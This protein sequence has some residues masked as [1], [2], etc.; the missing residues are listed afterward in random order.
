ME[1]DITSPNNLAPLNVNTLLFE[2]V[3]IT[4]SKFK[5]KAVCH[6][7]PNIGFVGRK[8]NKCIAKKVILKALKLKDKMIYLT[9]VR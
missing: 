7:N 6:L 2:I 5:L 9:S 3:P 4:E 1:I 8:L